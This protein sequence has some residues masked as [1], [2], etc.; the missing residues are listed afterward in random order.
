[1]DWL[2]A[3][4]N[5]FGSA[6]CHQWDSHSYIINGTPLSL[7]ARCTG[8]YLGVLLTLAYF[9]WRA[10][11]GAGL[12]RLPYLVAFLVVFFL[13]AGD[14]VNSY[15]T[16]VLRA[17]FLYQP[18]NL[19][20]LT[21]GMFVGIGLGGL[22]YMLLY[23]VAHPQARLEPHRPLFDE[24]RDIVILVALGVFSIALVNTQWAWLYYPL[25]ALL[26]LAMLLVVTTLCYVLLA[27][28][29]ESTGHVSGSWRYTILASLLSIGLL[30]V[31]AAMR[32]MSGYSFEPPI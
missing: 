23:S 28:L 32:A 5:W 18:Q 1:M 8:T 13:W 15:L 10:P 4:A 21:T 12:P 27:T 3:I 11:R 19:I 14:G 17:P 9:K 22:L 6:L 31:I 16:T 7:C 29:W 30:S 26:L 2:A 20:R 24:K 25:T